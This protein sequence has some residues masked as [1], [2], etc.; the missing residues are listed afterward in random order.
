[1]SHHPDGIYINPESGIK[2]TRAQRRQMKKNAARIDRISEA[3]RKFFER[4]PHRQYRLRL[5]GQAER[6]TQELVHSSL[7]ICRPGDRLFVLIQNIAPGTRLKVY[8]VG[9]D[10]MDTDLPESVV[11]R[12]WEETTAS[13]SEKVQEVKE[14]LPILTEGRS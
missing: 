10:G 2:L 7:R 5:A 14:A 1:M 13:V 6:E 4:F 9:L 12:L 11:Q 3:D 8:W